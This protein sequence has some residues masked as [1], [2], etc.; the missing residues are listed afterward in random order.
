MVFGWA[1]ANSYA[2]SKRI[3]KNELS[4]IQDSGLA[5]EEVVYA[6]ATALL[7]DLRRERPISVIH[8]RL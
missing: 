7:E 6:L 8:Y 3:H 4:G 2:H 5:F 1:A